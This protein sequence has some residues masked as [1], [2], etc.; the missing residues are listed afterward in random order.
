MP[1]T[2]YL[3]LGDTFGDPVF[4]GLFTTREAA[5]A[6]QLERGTLFGL[7]IQKP[8]IEVLEYDPATSEYVFKLNQES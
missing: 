2:L 6:A 8:D 4:W 3:L 5:E 7:A 1:T